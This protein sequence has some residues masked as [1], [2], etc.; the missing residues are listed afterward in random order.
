ME[1]ETKTTEKNSSICHTV[2]I[3]HILTYMRELKKKHFQVIFGCLVF[4]ASSE[5]K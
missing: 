2:V 5:G 1:Q 4:R 3:I